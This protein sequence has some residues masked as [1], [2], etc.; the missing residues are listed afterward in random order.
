MPAV[1]AVIV[2]AAHGKP[3]GS[4]VIILRLQSAVNGFQIIGSISD[5]CIG[6][7]Y[8]GRKPAAVANINIMRGTVEESIGGIFRIEPAVIIFPF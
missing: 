6:I 7:S 5:L 8:C 2:G 4:V 1:D 3:P